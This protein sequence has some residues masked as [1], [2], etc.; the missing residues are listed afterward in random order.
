MLLCSIYVKARKPELYKVLLEK[1]KRYREYIQRGFTHYDMSSIPTRNLDKLIREDKRLTIEREL[2][3]SQVIEALAYTKYLKKQSLLVQE[4]ID[5]LSTQVSTKLN[6][7][8]SINSTLVSR[9]SILK[10]STIDFPLLRNLFQNF[11]FENVIKE[12][13]YSIGFLL[14]LIYYLLRRILSILLDILPNQLQ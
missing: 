6:K 8:D 12:S 3:L 5:K 9:P 2:A 13:L 4:R 14:V 7:E 11:F 1:S 10:S